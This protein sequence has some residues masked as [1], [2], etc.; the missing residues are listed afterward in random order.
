[1]HQTFVSENYSFLFHHDSEISENLHL[2]M[3]QNKVKIQKNY[4]SENYSLLFH[5]GWRNVWKFTSPNALKCNENTQK[6]DIKWFKFDFQ[7][8]CSPD[9]SCNSSNWVSLHPAS[10]YIYIY[11]FRKTPDFRENSLTPQHLPDCIHPEIRFITM[12]F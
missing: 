4:V 7:S 10:T 6:P 11:I 3:L 9:F 8:I 1:M 12:A 5:H 2:K